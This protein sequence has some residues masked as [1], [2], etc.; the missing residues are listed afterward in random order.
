[1]RRT[2]PLR[3][4][5][6]P[7]TP[8]RTLEM[9]S[10]IPWRT[11]RGDHSSAS[12]SWP[13]RPRTPAPST[14][15]TG[16][17][18]ERSAGVVGDGRTHARSECGWSEGAGGAPARRDTSPRPA[19]SSPRDPTPLA[20][21]ARPTHNKSHKPRKENPKRKSQDHRPVF[22]VS[23]LLFNACCQAQRPNG[24]GPIAGAAAVS[25]RPG[26][27]VPC[28]SP[29]PSPGMDNGDDVPDSAPLSRAD[30]NEA[31]RRRNVARAAARQRRSA[32]AAEADQQQKQCRRFCLGVGP[33]PARAPTC[34]LAPRPCSQNPSL[35]SRA[36]HRVCGGCAGALAGARLGRCRLTQTDDRFRCRSVAVR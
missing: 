33:A 24:A 10:C 25:R 28:W 36:V 34:T 22:I 18:H 6:H 21:S 3:T 7:R 13:T 23:C 4:H 5:S 30:R 29:R 20:S 32:A 1:M 8:Q 16:G 9:R 19:A 27:C 31:I 15:A 2:Q 12:S 17:R 26:R 11:R 35:C 14:S